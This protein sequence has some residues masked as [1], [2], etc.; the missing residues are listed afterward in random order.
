M[1]RF[2]AIAG[3]LALL[4]ACT[5]SSGAETGVADDPVAEGG[6]CG[7]GL[8]VCKPGSWCDPEPG[9]CEAEGAT[10]VCV[11]VPQMCTHDYRPVCGCDGR[12]YGNDCARRSAK[13]A[14]DRDGEC[15]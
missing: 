13:V 7:G 14:L 10:G 12:T 8:G 6:R 15:S 11:A 9:L 1:G 4:A 5:S 3:A 2:V